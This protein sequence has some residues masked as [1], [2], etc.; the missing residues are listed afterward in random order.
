MPPTPPEARP[1]AV[2]SLPGLQASCWLALVVVVCYANALTGDFQFDDYK[3]IVDNPGVHSWAAWGEQLGHG[4]RPLLKLSYTLNW[5]S[6]WGVAGFHAVNVL[7]HLCNVLL[8]FGLARAFVRAQPASARLHPVP[9]LSALLFAVHPAH[10]EA[11][12]YVCGRSSSLMAL[13]YLAGLLAYARASGAAWQQK[14]G[15]YG[16]TPLLFLAALGVKETAVTFPFALLLW[17]WCTGGTARSALQKQWP[18][19]GGWLVAAGLFLF[20]DSYLSQM[21]RSVEFNSLQ[22][23]AATQVSALVYLMRQWAMP[24]WL[25]ID[26]DLPLLH[27]F[28]GTGLKLLVLALALAGAGACWR[29]RPW[30]IFALVWVLLQLVALYLFLPRLDIANDRQ[31]YLADWP[32]F[33]ALSAEM[34]LVWT[35]R[36]V[37]IGA[38][39]LVLALGGLTVLRNPVYRDEITLWEN[40]VVQSPDKAR[41]H[42]NLGYAYHLSGRDTEARR[43]FTRALAIDPS[44]IKARYNLE[45][46]NSP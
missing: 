10:T 24:L 8:V 41:V 39:A 1:D 45:R 21:Q 37:R 40:T 33:L 19:W 42:N 29:S 35:S 7:I 3:V 12:T 11:V 46:L 20:S 28:A 14:V 31:L 15:R 38:L 30:L 22:G 27:D 2:A 18:V 34:A 17:E 32:L 43:E 6:G 36:P 26:P 4:I 9:L 5:T 25:N 16:L 23:N 44:H 13:F